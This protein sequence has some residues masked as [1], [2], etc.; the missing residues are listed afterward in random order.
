MRWFAGSEPITVQAVSRVTDPEGEVAD[1]LSCLVTFGNGVVGASEIVNRLPPD[2]HV[3]HMA[4]VLGSHGS[5]RAFDTE[6]A[7]ATISTATGTTFPAN[8]GVL[9]HIDSAY[10][11]ELRGFALAVRGGGAVPMDPW[12]ARQAVAM[13]LAAVRSS[14]LGR[15]VQMTEMEP[16]DSA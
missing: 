13:S 10:A 8:W 1:F 9:L 6:M 5:A 16:G 12:E 4:E 7:P 11:V 14:E 2:H 3:Y 15:A